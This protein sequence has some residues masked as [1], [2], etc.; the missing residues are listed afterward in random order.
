[1][2]ENAQYEFTSCPQNHQEYDQQNYLN[3]PFQFFCFW[4]RFIHDENLLAPANFG[5]ILDSN[6][7]CFVKIPIKMD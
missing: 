2:L 1:M 4:I 3:Q 5:W 7:F 6:R